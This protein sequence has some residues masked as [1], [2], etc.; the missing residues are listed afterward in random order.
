M[1]VL[2]AVVVQDSPGNNAT[3]CI[4][5]SASPLACQCYHASKL[6]IDSTLHD[7]YDLY[8]ETFEMALHRP[9]T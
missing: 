4:Q 8:S 7:A 9:F 5:Y 2:G 3:L 1:I 6:T